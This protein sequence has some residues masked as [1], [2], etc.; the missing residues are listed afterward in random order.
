MAQHW[1]Q[2]DEQRVGRVRHGENTVTLLA[3]RISVR[4]PFGRGAFFWLRPT[5][6]MLERGSEPVVRLPVR[7]VTLQVQLGLLLLGATIV[8]LAWWA[9]RRR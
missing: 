4:M 7:N 3:R 6:I 5:A 2:I 9:A 1:L 8:A